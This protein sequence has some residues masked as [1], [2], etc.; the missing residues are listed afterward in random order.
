VVELDQIQVLD[1]DQDG[2]VATAGNTL[3]EVHGIFSP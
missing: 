3:F 1:G 2:R